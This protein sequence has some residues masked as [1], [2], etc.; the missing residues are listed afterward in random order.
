MSVRKFIGHGLLYKYSAGNFNIVLHCE[1]FYW[2][3]G[4]KINK[5]NYQELGINGS[6]TDWIGLLYVQ[7]RCI[8]YGFV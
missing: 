7:W 3:N 2:G 5:M 8:A 1:W 4:L 6:V